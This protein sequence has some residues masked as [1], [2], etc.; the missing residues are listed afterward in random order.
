M[1]TESEGRMD[2]VNKSV[3]VT[4]EDGKR[5]GRRESE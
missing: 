3:G 5:D 4:K 1:R 2:V